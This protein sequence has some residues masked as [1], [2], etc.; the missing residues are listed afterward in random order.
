MRNLLTSSDANVP[1]DGVG[2]SESAEINQRLS[3]GLVVEHETV[4]CQYIGTN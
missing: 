1:C 2:V 3:S 4:Q